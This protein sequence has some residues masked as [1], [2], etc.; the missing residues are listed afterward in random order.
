L[1]WQIED[2]KL[3]NSNIL[4]DISSKEI[5]ENILMIILKKSQPEKRK[6]SML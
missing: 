1:A 6:K 2:G 3:F 5:E 4:N